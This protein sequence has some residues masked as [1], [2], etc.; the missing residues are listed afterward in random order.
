MTGW[1]SAAQV[2]LALAAFHV[3]HRPGDPAGKE[4]LEKMLKE[5]GFPK[6]FDAP[7]G[8]F[9]PDRLP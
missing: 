3:S 8:N 9:R 5:L 6:G 2:Y 1:D 4:E 7:S